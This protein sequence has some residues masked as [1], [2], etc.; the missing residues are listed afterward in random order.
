MSGTNIFGYVVLFFLLQENSRP[1]VPQQSSQIQFFNAQNFKCS[2]C[3]TKLR[4]S[5]KSVTF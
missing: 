1:E 3:D 4:V 5:V 2:K